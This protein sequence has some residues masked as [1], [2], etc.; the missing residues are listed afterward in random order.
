MAGMDIFNNDA[1]RTREL[2]DAVNVIPN[3]WGRIGDLGLFAPKPLRSTQFQIESK[4][5]ILQ[6]VQSSARGTALGNQKNG[7]REMRNFSTSRFGLEDQITADDISGIRAFGSETELKQVQEEVNDRMESLRGS[8]DITREYL[9][10][11]AIAGQVKDADGTTI[12]D[13]FVDFGVAQKVVDFD[14]G[15]G[16]TDHAAKAREV[17]D[18]IRTNL[19]GDSMTGIRALCS[20]EFY[21]KLLSNDEFKEAHKYYTSTVEPLRDDPQGGVPWQGII[22]EKYLGE[23][24]VPQEDGSILTKK[25]IAAGDARFFPEGTR[26]TFRQYNAP[27][28]YM[29]VVNTKGIPFNAKVMPDPKA[30]RFV[31]VEVQ[32]NTL[33]I[34]MRP[35]VLVRGHSST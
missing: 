17:S 14:F 34:C 6:L 2:S 18:H 32:M 8:I 12:T 15:T 16:S 3:M 20:V 23:A 33:P 26:T 31:D 4:N 29:E 13:L 30:N 35:A 22:W 25:F 24:G 5:G 19:M 10:S 28:D 11:G 9:R 27:A 1:F 21:D 7:K